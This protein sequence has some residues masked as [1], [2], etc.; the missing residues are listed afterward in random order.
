MVSEKCSAPQ[1]ELPQLRIHE[2]SFFS[3]FSPF[4]FFLDLAPQKK[5]K[6]DE[7]AKEDE[8]DGKAKTEEQ[9]STDEKDT[10]AG[11]DA[12]ENSVPA[13][14]SNAASETKQEVE[15]SAPAPSADADAAPVPAG[16]PPGVPTGDSAKPVDP[17]AVASVS[18]PNSIIEERGEVSP[19]Y[20]GRVIGKGGEMIRDLQARA[21]CR[22]DVDQQVPPGQPRVIT[23]RGTRAQIDFAKHLVQLLCREN[24][25]DADL[26]LGNAKR[27]Y[28]VVPGQS[29][30]KIIGRG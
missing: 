19:L 6:V 11:E 20:V 21:G 5:Q 26:P 12:K 4:M 30:G 10:A 7:S 18:N 17:N 9:T 3:D 13:E 27:E 25:T 1:K 28:L 8:G 29:V 2:D 22:I 14:A 24:A 15:D 23:Y 16:L